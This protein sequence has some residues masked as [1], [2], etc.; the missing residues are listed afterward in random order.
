M[1]PLENITLVDRVEK[2]IADYIRKNDLKPGD[3]LPK[4]VELA[5]WLG[6]SRT[7]VREA[8]LRMRTLGLVESKKHR[9]TVLKEPDFISNIQKTL[10]TKMLDESTLRDLFEFRLMFE[11][12]MVDFVFARKTQAQVQ[13]L[14]A[15]ARRA[16]YEYVNNY[17]SLKDEFEFHS[18]L[19]KMADNQTLLR[20]QELLLPVFQ[21]VHDLQ[22]KEI[23]FLKENKRL[24]THIDLVEE[25][26]K[27]TP[28]SFREAMR[29][30]LNPHFERISAEK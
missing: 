20:F 1:E 12:G 21:Y 26:K 11:I 25:L 16:N 15:L 8:M 18:T 2:R 23:P 7:V 24:V 17:F 27:G 5:T 19:Y 14:E 28:Q 30:H 22:A 6:V 10:D 4:E 29:E 9:G 13:E 3:S